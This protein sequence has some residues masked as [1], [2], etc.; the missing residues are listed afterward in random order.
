MQIARCTPT[1]RHF[2]QNVNLYVTNQFLVSWSD[3][4]RSPWDP[5]TPPGVRIFFLKKVPPF[6][7]N[8]NRCRHFVL[9]NSI[10]WPCTGPMQSNSN[11]IAGRWRKKRQPRTHGV[12]QPINYSNFNFHTLATPT[13]FISKK[14]P[15]LRRCR[16]KIFKSFRNEWTSI[17]PIKV[18]HFL[19][20]GCVIKGGRPLIHSDGPDGWWAHPAKQFPPKMTSNQTS[21]SAIS[22]IYRPLLIIP[23]T[24][25]YLPPQTNTRGCSLPNRVCGYIFKK[26]PSIF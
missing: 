8:S 15:A 7:K 9:F 5:L 26:I 12:T 13:P 17:D 20:S 18:K 1:S 4:K 14:F 21:I 22:A 24:G 6:T 25:P 16:F 2:P 23:L 11:R 3:R 19:S 10:L